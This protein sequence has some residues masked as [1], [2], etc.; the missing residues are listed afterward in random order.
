MS[1]PKTEIQ[2]AQTSTKCDASKP[3]RLRALRPRLDICRVTRRRYAAYDKLYIVLGGWRGEFTIAELC[4]RLP[5]SA[6]C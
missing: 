3:V 6:A 5:T 4:R 2:T 1:G